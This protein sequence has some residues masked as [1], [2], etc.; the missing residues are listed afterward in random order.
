MYVPIP[1]LTLT[2]KKE[3]G[4]EMEGKKR[5]KERKREGKIKK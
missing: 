4:S 1:C 3:K 2:T 5:G